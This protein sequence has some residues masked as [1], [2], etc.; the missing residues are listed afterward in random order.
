MNEDMFI[1]CVVKSA[2]NQASLQVITLARSFLCVS[3]IH[4]RHQT[5]HGRSLNPP[6]TLPPFPPHADTT[7]SCSVLC[8]S[9]GQCQLAANP[10][11]TYTSFGD[12]ITNLNCTYQPRVDGSNC[13]DGHCLAG[14]CVP[15]ALLVP[16]LGAAC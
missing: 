8:A 15:G 9:P 1:I 16:P 3:H 7:P 12:S 2:L 4:L 6:R 5:Q 11:C 10:N 13:T 14:V